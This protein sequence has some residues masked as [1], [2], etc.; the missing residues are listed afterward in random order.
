MNHSSKIYI[1]GHE[2]FLGQAIVRKL[3][4]QGYQNLIYSPKAEL[5]LTH[6]QAVLDWFIKH[7]PDYVFHAAATVRGITSEEQGTIILNNL[8]IQTNVIQAAHLNKTKKFL[9]L[10]SSCM[11]PKISDQPIK[12]Q[13]ILS[14]FLE[15]T[16]EYYAIAKIAGLKLCEALKRQFNFNYCALIPCNI[17]GPGD[18]Y[19][20][21]RSHVMAA[22]IKKF[23]NAINKQIPYVEL[24]GDGS[25]RR[26][27]LYIDDAA[28]ASISA[29]LSK[30]TVL[31][32]K[33]SPEIT[34]MEL[35]NLL[36]KITGFSGEIR[37]N[38]SKPNGTFSKSL[39]D[40]DLRKTGWLPHFSI[41]EGIKRS[42]IDYTQRLDV[43]AKNSHH[44][45]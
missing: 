14:G 20:D 1:S 38:N 4:D 22:M 42:V 37:W 34:I 17:Y 28:S 21:L 3:K 44:R 26:E 24:W 10:G 27:F 6:Q 19:D 33:S 16:S 35:A 29:M 2:G 30:H 18:N 36:K 9:F 31:N 13:Q 25:P 23:I 15:P 11:Y 8:L 45:N 32:V 40:S 5:D 41:E 39:D 43:Y 7:K 12:P